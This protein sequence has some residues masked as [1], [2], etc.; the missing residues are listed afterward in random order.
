M[1]VPFLKEEICRQLNRLSGFADGNAAPPTEANNAWSA[2]PAF[3]GAYAVP[4]QISEASNQK[5]GCFEGASGSRPDGGYHY[6]KV[7]LAR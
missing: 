2:S 3:Q 5:S 1:V 7:L 6:F 4:E